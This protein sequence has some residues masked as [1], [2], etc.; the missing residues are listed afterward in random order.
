MR[1]FIYK[2][3]DEAKLLNEIHICSTVMKFN[4]VNVKLKKFTQKL[5]L[6]HEA[7]NINRCVSLLMESPSAVNI[8]REP[9]G[10]TPFLVSWP[11]YFSYMDNI[12]WV[13]YINYRMPVG[14]DANLW[15]ASCC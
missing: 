4:V 1:A 2:V 15:C 10:F 7:N 9:F 8:P 12:V 3:Q 6:A 13:M 14:P 11:K 5:Q